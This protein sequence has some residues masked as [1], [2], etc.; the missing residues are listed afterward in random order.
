MKWTNCLSIS[1]GFE[2]LEN[3]AI[4]YETWPALALWEMQARLVWVW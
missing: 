1:I 4:D 2:I 3:D